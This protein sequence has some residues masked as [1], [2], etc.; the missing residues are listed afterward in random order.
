MALCSSIR[1]ALLAALGALCVAATV[2]AAPYTELLVTTTRFGDMEFDWGRDGVYCPSC[3]AGDGNA[4]FHWVDR[5]NRLWISY[6][7]FNT[8]AIYPPNGR[9]VLVDSD[10]AYYSDFGNGP[11]WVFSQGDSQIVYTKYKAGAEQT[12]ANA[13]L[14][15]AKVVNG[16]W[17]AGFIDGAL[18]RITPA[19]SQSIGDATP[20]MMYASGTGPQIYW[21]KLGEPV[22]AEKRAPWISTGL[23]ARWLPNTNK[24]AYVNGAAHEDGTRYQQVFLFDS[25]TNTIEQLTFDATEKRGVFMLPAPEFGGEMV[26]F[27]VAARTQLRLYRQLLGSDGLRRWTVVKTVTAP[28]E[29][30]YLATPEPFVH[31]GRTYV[32]MTLSSSKGASDITVPT[33]LALTGIDP[34]V[35]DFRQLT[36][37]SSPVRLRQDPEYFITAQGPFLYFSRAL[38]GTDTS[39]PVNE[40]VFRIDLKLGAPVR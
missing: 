13:G 18:G 28:A 25:D 4:R 34:A 5:S 9:G 37:A 31:N 32:F 36:D 19:P 23:S 29:V 35:D 7:D 22:G 39:G 17:S 15:L 27:T 8:G 20:K 33:R 3:N 12:G 30:P 14:G 2:Q 21:R 16:S 38:P 26:F 40:G 11:E 24:L 6:I 1:G 10:V